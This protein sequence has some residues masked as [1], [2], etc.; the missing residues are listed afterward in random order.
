[1]LYSSVASRWASPSSGRRRASSPSLPAQAAAISLGQSAPQGARAA[2]K[3]ANGSP[4]APDLDAG[5]DGDHGVAA[6]GRRDELLDQAGHCRRPPRR[7]SAAP[8]DRRKRPDASASVS[9]ASSSARPTN[10]GLTDLFS[11]PPS[12]AYAYEAAGVHSRR[13]D[14]APRT[15]R[16]RRRPRSR[17]AASGPAAPGPEGR[18]A[19]GP[20][21]GAGIVPGRAIVRAAGAKRLR[22]LCLTF[23]SGSWRPVRRRR[24]GGRGGPGRSRARRPPGGSA[25]RR[26]SGRSRTRTCAPL[27]PGRGSGPEGVR[28]V[29]R[30]PVFAVCPLSSARW[31]WGIGRVPHLRGDGGL[32]RAR[33]VPEGRTGP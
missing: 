26:R 29:G 21:S 7:R 17:R 25:R 31:G 22:S 23:P 10:T 19:A 32:R 20:G 1:M 24:P 15:V 16:A 30:G 8:A 11:T 9:E 12:I 6:L 27:I 3:G 33:P 5:S 28:P 18:A 4:S 13:G 2:G 14:H